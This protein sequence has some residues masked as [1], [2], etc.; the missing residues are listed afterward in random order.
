MILLT[1]LKPGALIRWAG[2]RHSTDALMKVIRVSARTVNL[3][4]VRGSH[5][6]KSHFKQPLDHVL[7]NGM[8]EDK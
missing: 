7:R 6:G 8:L 3:R 5:T 2:G 1:D 4:N